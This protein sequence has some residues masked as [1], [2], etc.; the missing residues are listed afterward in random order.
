[1][2][3]HTAGSSV[4]KGL[5]GA[6]AL[7]GTTQAYGAVVAGNAPLTST[8]TGTAAN[9]GAY[10]SWDIDGDGVLDFTVGAAVDRAGG[11]PPLQQPDSITSVNGVYSSEM[12][13]GYIRYSPV[14][15]RNIYCSNL[16][17]GTT[18]GAASTFPALN[19]VYGFLGNRY[20]AT[21]NGQFPNTTGYIGFRFVE[22]GQ[23]HYGYAEFSSVLTG[24]T[25]ADATCTVT[26]LGSYYETAANTPIIVGAVPEPG[27]LAALAFGVAGAAGVAACR[28][29]KSA[30][31]REMVVDAFV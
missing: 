16:A 24:S 18:V 7:A 11:N 23:L 30:T 15:G 17:V 5:A 29:R 1:M 3:K 31:G 9:R 21:T 20:G 2:D 22:S 19:D 26:Y 14:F 10:T 8:I 6:V 28:R 25:N 13:V 27:S 12:A 4:I